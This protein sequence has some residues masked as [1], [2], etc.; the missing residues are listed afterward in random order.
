M[1]GITAAATTTILPNHTA[2]ILQIQLGCTPYRLL[3][4]IGGGLCT[5]EHRCTGTWSVLFPIQV[6]YDVVV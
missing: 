5:A 1:C 4:T 2:T 3:K 6:V